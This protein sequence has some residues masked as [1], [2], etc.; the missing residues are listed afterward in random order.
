MGLRYRFGQAATAKIAEARVRLGSDSDASALRELLAL[1]GTLARYT[2]DDG[3]L[4][5]EDPGTS[6]YD[7]VP[8]L[9]R[10]WRGAL[11]AGARSD[12]LLTVHYGSLLPQIVDASSHLDLDCL[13]TTLQAMVVIGI[14]ASHYM[15]RRGVRVWNPE[16][17]LDHAV[18][19]PAVAVARETASPSVR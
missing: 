17:G 11:E 19:L 5:F 15:D 12:R 4:W 7:R 10:D 3:A 1:G 14:D 16:T 9:G 13:E 6:R 8:V 18:R 2:A